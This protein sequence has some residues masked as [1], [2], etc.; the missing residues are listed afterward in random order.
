MLA[1]KQIYFKQILNI[2]GHFFRTSKFR[3]GITQNRKYMVWMVLL[4][5]EIQTSRDTLIYQGTDPTREQT[6]LIKIAQVANFECEMLPANCSPRS[7]QRR[8]ISRSDSAN[9]SRKLQSLRGRFTNGRC[10]LLNDIHYKQFFCLYLSL[11]KQSG[12]SGG[13]FN[14]YKTCNAQCLQ[15]RQFYAELLHKVIKK[16]CLMSKTRYG[17]RFSSFSCFSCF[18]F[19][20]RVAIIAQ[21]A[22]ILP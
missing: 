11:W 22:V 21:R 17:E 10:S 4:R 3:H 1:K 20:H 19:P 6:H 2:S 12:L 7:C 16:L 15:A 18:P 9:S 5:T 8:M 14:I 13:P